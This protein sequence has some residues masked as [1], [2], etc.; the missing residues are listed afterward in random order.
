MKKT[1]EPMDW[2]LSGFWLAVVLA[3]LIIGFTIGW[4][5]RDRPGALA[6]VSFL[7][8]MTAIGTV[9]T[10][11]AA[12]WLS[13]RDAAR[14]RAENARKVEM[15]VIRA[16]PHIEYLRSCLTTA[17]HAA[18]ARAK[19]PDG[20]A[21]PAWHD[22]QYR[23]VL[24]AIGGMDLVAVLPDLIHDDANRG[25]MLAEVLSM[26]PIVSNRTDEILSLGKI[27]GNGHAIFAFILLEEMCKLGQK[28]NQYLSRPTEAIF[29]LASYEPIAVT[30][31]IRPPSRP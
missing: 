17:V 29:A 8:V 22:F 6:N 11:L 12:V 7:N 31:G 27:Q 19:F 28:L 5:W 18:A 26:I 20:K 21:V 2:R 9:G 16:R 30:L 13:M 23:R 15:A 1:H 14:V 10:A 24:G 3:A 25:V 4:L